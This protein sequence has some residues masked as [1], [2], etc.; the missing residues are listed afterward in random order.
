MDEYEY[1]AQDYKK[2]ITAQNAIE[3][4]V[5]TNCIEDSNLVPMLSEQLQRRLI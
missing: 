4:W 1:T 3:K 2:Q 5:K